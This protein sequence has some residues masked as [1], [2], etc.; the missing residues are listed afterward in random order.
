MRGACS[1][2]SEALGDRR[3]AWQRLADAALHTQRATTRGVELAYRSEEGVE[4]QLR[5]LAALEAECCSFADWAVD[6][7]GEDV[8]LTVTTAPESVAAVHD[9]FGLA[10]RRMTSRGALSDRPRP[11]PTPIGSR[12]A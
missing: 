4:G 1:L 11:V 2:T 8:L 12:T 5:E 3:Q 9:L 6:R 7:R 10:P